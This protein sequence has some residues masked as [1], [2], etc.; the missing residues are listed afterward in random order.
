MAG[1]TV[2]N[3]VRNER[4]FRSSAAACSR[5]ERIGAIVVSKP[6]ARKTISFPGASAAACSASRGE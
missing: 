6:T 5:T 3:A 2:L 4:F 1:T